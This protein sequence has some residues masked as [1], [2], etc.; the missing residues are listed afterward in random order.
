MVM[1]R[2]CWMKVMRMRRLG[3]L[4]RWMRRRCFLTTQ[5]TKPSPTLN[6]VPNPG[7][8]QPLLPSSTQTGHTKFSLN[9][10]ELF[11]VR[12]FL[13]ERFLLRY[14]LTRRK[15]HNLLLV[16]YLI[17]SATFSLQNKLIIEPILLE[18]KISLMCMNT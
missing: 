4:R 18:T 13:K 10:S 9:S 5:K 3:M 17:E 14:V 11:Y 7:C 8:N 16:K 12:G 2:V 6:H 15:I 1:R